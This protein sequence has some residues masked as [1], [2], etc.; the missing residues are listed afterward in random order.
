MGKCMTLFNTENVEVDYPETDN[1]YRNGILI[2]SDGYFKVTVNKPFAGFF[3]KIMIDHYNVDTPF[4]LAV[5]VPSNAAIYT[6]GHTY[7]VFTKVSGTTVIIRQGMNNMFYF[8]A[9]S[10][11]D[12]VFGLSS[13]RRAVKGSHH[14]HHH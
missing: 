12:S 4:S 9:S 11:D 1:S 10:T 5:Q 14:G 8:Q 7:N 3:V 13:V 2:S 6:M